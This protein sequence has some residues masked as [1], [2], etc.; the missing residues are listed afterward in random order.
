MEI[1][2]FYLNWCVKCISHI[3]LRYHCV[4]MTGCCMNCE[5]TIYVWIP[6][7]HLQI[8][9]TQKH[10]GTLPRLVTR[11][12]DNHL[13]T[14]RGV[15]SRVTAV[16][17]P[18]VMSCLDRVTMLHHQTMSHS[19][20]LQRFILETLKTILTQHS[21]WTVWLCSYCCSGLVV[22]AGTKKPCISPLLMRVVCSLCWLS[23]PHY[24]CRGSRRNIRIQIGTHPPPPHSHYIL[25]SDFNGG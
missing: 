23:S 21:W 11:P 14:W 2:H 10:P 16:T 6:P 3:P 12:R 17:Q 7:Q 19:R 18:A 22:T 4:D 20:T 25:Q 13:T 5:Y 8:Y 1:F 9:F 15:T 24:G